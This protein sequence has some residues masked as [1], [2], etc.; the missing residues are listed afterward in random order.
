MF[1][2]AAKLFIPDHNERSE[3]DSI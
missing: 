3:L 2:L 1:F